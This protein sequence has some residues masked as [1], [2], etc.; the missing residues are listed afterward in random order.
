MC[1]VQFIFEFK[2]K[3]KYKISISIIMKYVCVQNT[4][5]AQ[6]KK[7]ALEMANRL[8]ERGEEYADFVRYSDLGYA[9]TIKR[10]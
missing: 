4:E 8:F 9:F 1:G 7:D 6:N 2:N 3:F 10:D 5:I